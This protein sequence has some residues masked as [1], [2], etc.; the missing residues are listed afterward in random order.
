[1]NESNMDFEKLPVEYQEG[2]KA[3]G[4]YFTNYSASVDD[5]S[6]KVVDSLR[7]ASESEIG[8]KDLAGY[9]E[10]TAKVWYEF[11]SGPME[12]DEDCIEMARTVLGL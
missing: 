6:D 8:E 1:M 2:L 11:V 5:P 3:S 12:T 10:S 4:K 7:F 9:E